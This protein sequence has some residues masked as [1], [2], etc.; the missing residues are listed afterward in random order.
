VRP[1]EGVHRKVGKSAFSKATTQP[2]LSRDPTHRSSGKLVSAYRKA[3]AA[4]QRI[5]DL[6]AA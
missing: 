1:A 4:I 3:D 5:V 6:F 2:L